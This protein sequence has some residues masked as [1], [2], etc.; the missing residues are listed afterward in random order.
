MHG[1]TLHIE[2][3]LAISGEMAWQELYWLAEQAARSAYIIEIGSWQGRSTR[4]LGD[5]TPGQVVSIDSFQGIPAQ[6]EL[7]GDKLYATCRK[8]LQ[9]LIDIGRVTLLRGSSEHHLPLLA[10]R[11]QADFIFIDGDHTFENVMRDMKLSW[12][13]LRK[14]GLFSG[15]DYGKHWPGVIQAVT[16]FTKGA[17]LFRTKRT[18][19]SVIK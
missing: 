10:T 5:H 15:H 11:T 3:A 12:P 7:Q 17:R 8:N 6:P 4:V 19:W 9:D 1:I 14:G 2:K 18:I 13:L 16:E